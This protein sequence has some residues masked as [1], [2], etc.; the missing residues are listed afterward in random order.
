VQCHQ[1]PAYCVEWH[2]SHKGILAS[3]G[4]DRLIKLWD[5][6]A[7]STTT[8]TLLIHTTAEVLRVSWRPRFKNQLASCSL[9]ND[10][11]VH[12]WDI[13]RPLCPVVSL[14]QHRKAVSSFV[15]SDDASAMF[16]VSED[17]TLQRQAVAQ[18]IHTFEE[19]NTVQTCFTPAGTCINIGSAIDRSRAFVA[20]PQ[21]S[22]DKLFLQT[23]SAAAAAASAASAATPSKALSVSTSTP[24]PAPPLSRRGHGLLRFWDGVASGF[25]DAAE[26]LQLHIGSSVPPCPEIFRFLCRNYSISS[27]TLVDAAASNATAAAEAGL[28]LISALWQLISCL[29][30]REQ[31]Q[32][33][34]RHTQAAARA[35]AGADFTSMPQYCMQICLPALVLNY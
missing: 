1:P 6:A 35:A 12:I 22:D 2:P 15:W 3:G 24:R 5:M 4:R 31:Y 10:N 29:F 32:Q 28:P 11:S 16:S 17:M 21:Q 18:G 13:S 30:T 14:K 25:V 20:T 7:P 26:A 9:V 19:Y 34:I 23:L 8:H 27:P 33:L